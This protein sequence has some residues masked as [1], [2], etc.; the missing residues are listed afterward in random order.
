MNPKAFPLADASLTNTILDL[1]QQASHYKQLKK[2]ANE[3]TKTLNRGISEFIVMTG[4]L[5][6][7]FWFF[8]PLCWRD[9]QAVAKSCRQSP[10]RSLPLFI[11]MIF[12][13]HTHPSHFLQLTLSPLKFFFTCLYCAKTRTCLTSLFPPRL[14]LVVPAVFPVPLLLALSPLTKLRTSSLRFWLSRLKS[15]S[16]WSKLTTNG[17][18]KVFFNVHVDKNLFKTEWGASSIITHQQHRY[19]IAS[20]FFP[21]HVQK[22]N[23]YIELQ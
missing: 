12:H 19:S 6:I 18:K 8:W 7:Y 9:R 13:T 4:K 20:Y 5:P 21:N 16:C 10:K 11:D 15:R 23:M 3:A 22:N 17:T 14:L 2:G 1:V